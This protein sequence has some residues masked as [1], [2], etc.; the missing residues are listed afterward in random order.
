MQSE[1]QQSNTP[2]QRKGELSWQKVVLYLGLAMCGTYSVFQIVS[3]EQAIIRS[4]GKRCRQFASS[5]S[6]SD[7]RANR[8]R[9]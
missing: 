3:C 6:S 8:F 9:N 7:R 5:K 4:I 1:G 2:V